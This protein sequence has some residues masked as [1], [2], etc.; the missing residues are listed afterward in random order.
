VKEKNLPLVSVV[1]PSYN[2][3]KYITET[4]ES[5]LNQTYKNI[6]LIVIDD[7][8][9][10]NSVNVI[11]ELAY[12]Y[13]FSFIHRKNKGVSFTINEGIRNSNGNYICFCASDDYYHRNKIKE[14]INFFAIN[15]EKMMCYHN[16]FLVRDA[17]IIEKKIDEYN[18]DIFQEIFLQKFHIPAVSVMVK[19]TVFIDVGYFDESIKIEDLDMWLR[20][21]KKYNIGYLNKTLAYTRIHDSNISSNIELMEK[22][23]LKIINKWKNDFLYNKALKSHKNKFK[24]KKIKSFLKSKKYFI[25]LINL[26][27]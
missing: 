1:V 10:D 19:K 8:S 26:I 23:E 12:K 18:G 27:K 25:K 22:E 24:I 5:I 16:M 20:I 6:E 7:G 2:H 9:K 11:Q 15:E 17:N 14:Q 3:G 4:I 13:H 21:S